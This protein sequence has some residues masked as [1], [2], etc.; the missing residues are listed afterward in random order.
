MF[1]DPFGLYAVA[2]REWYDSK[3]EYISENYSNAS[4]SLTWNDKTKT[5]SVS[6]SA[7]GY[8]GYIGFTAGI[9]GSCIIDDRMYVENTLLWNAFGKVIDPPAEVKTPGQTVAVMTDHIPL[10]HY[11]QAAIGRDFDGNKL[12]PSQSQLS[13]PSSFRR[14]AGLFEVSFLFIFTFINWRWR[15]VF[16]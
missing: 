3:L 8:N 15:L 5:A 12:S 14:M 7:N 11:A 6:L 10:I 13:Q 1:L 2:L 4:G 16:Q 9:N